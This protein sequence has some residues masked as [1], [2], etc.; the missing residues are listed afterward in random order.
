MAA[1]SGSRAD[2]PSGDA[3]AEVAAGG[4]GAKHDSAGSGTGSRGHY[5]SSQGSGLNSQS[6]A[7]GTGRGTSAG[8][9]AGTGSETGQGSGTGAGSAPG[10]GGFPGITIQGGRYGN[11]GNMQAKV[12]P[13]RQI[14]YNMNIVSTAS[15]GGGLPELG[16]FQ[17]E[18]V[19]TVYLDMR[20]N[21]EDPTPSWT[22]QYAVL[23]P[24]AGD[25]GVPA[26]HIQGTP[27]PPYAILKLVPEFT[28]ELVRKCARRLIVASATMDVSGKLDQV[29]VRQS[30][31]SELVGPLVEALKHWVFEPAQI[32]GRPVALKILLGIRLGASR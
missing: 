14:S 30:P 10:G 16:V 8:S 15:S 26:G 32:D 2:I 11:T 18:K 9:A 4:D 12:E 17:N 19:Y 31:E 22:L 6:T 3:L 23:Q 1:G 25:P 21:D 24:A 5:G 7:S 28:P 27:T 29:S 20:A 13:R